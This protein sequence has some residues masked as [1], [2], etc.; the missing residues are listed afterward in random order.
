VIRVLLTTLIVVVIS[1]CRVGGSDPNPLEDLRSEP[2][3]YVEMVMASPVIIRVYASSESIARRAVRDAYDR[4]HALEL[5]L[6]DWMEESESNRLEAAAPEAIEI[7]DD[8]RHAITI[9]RTL[10]QD[11]DGMFDPT[12]GPLVDLWRKTRNSG[13]MPQDEEIRLARSRVD[14]DSIELLAKT[15]RINRR[16]VELDFGAI[17]KGIALDA[18]SVVLDAYGL[19]RHLIN[20]DGEILTGDTPP[21]KDSW[22]ITIL[23]TGTEETLI[24]DATRASIATSG[25]VN[26]FLELGGVRYSHIID[27]STG[28]GTSCAR[29]VTVVADSATHADVLATV[30]C[31]VDVARFEEILQTRFEGA[32]AVIMENEGTTTNITRIG[33]PPVR[34]H[35]AP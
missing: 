23:P 20:F 11:T 17:G 7:S 2:Y 15:A 19:N 27:P 31:I 5:T 14:L 33:D 30:G 1:A 6:S 29:Q 35:D 24:I 21:G 32:S 9:S 4:M 8:L 3:E 12:I 13:R 28:I 18:A 10:W 26:Q 34:V 16:D 25:G 22:Q